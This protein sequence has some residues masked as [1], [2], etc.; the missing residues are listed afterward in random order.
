MTKKLKY[1]SPSFEFVIE[2]RFVRLSIGN[3]ELCKT[4]YGRIFDL[5]VKSK[6]VGLNNRNKDHLPQLSL[7]CVCVHS[8]GPV[9][10]IWGN[11]GFQSFSPSFYC[12]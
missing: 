9:E 4:L 12:Y 5:R 7:V 6:Y 11:C 8:L 1:R 10:V 2:N 3:T